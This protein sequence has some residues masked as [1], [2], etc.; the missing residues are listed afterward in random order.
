MNIKEIK[1]GS[2]LY[3]DEGHMIREEGREET[4]RI[5]V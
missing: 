5:A 1:E 2:H 4:R 3:I